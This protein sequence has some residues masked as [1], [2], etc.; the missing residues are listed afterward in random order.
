MKA[1]VGISVI[2]LL[3]GAVAPLHAA[4]YFASANCEGKFDSESG[5]D[6]AG[7]VCSNSA[8]STA[9]LSASSEADASGLHAAA[10]GADFNDASA[11]AVLTDNYFVA[12]GGPPGT[13]GTLD[14]T[15]YVHG[16]SADPSAMGSVLVTADNTNV[17]TDPA[18]AIVFEKDING[19]AVIAGTGTLGVG[20]TIGVPTAVETDLHVLSLQGFIDFSD[21]VELVG[22]QAFD[23]DGH[24]ISA[25]ITGDGGFNYSALAAS[26]AAALGLNAGSVPE[27]STWMMLLA[28]FVSLGGAMLFRSR[29]GAA[30][31]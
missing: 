31:V 3:L 10:H 5:A 8:S 29:S 25:T 16:I 17:F 13:P 1:I 28:G 7:A 2:G 27:A 19:A 30:A 11:D 23:S 20:V 18:A 4:E 15:Y 6:F 12:S 21:T 9:F 26:N 22:I 24:P 14:F